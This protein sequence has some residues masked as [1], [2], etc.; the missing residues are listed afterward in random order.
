MYGYEVVIPLEIQILSLQVALATKMTQGDN[1][2]LHL[3]KLEVLEVTTG[4][5][6]Y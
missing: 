1:D 4:S 5:T 6:A 2:Q 3:Q